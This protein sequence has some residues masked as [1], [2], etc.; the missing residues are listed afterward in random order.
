MCLVNYFNLRVYV[1][2]GSETI[3]YLGNYKAWENNAYINR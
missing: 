1:D 3:S 2:Y